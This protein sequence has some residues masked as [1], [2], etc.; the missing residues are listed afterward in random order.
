M[1]AEWLTFTGGSVR[2]SHAWRQTT[3]YRETLCVQQCGFVT[4]TP[5]WLTCTAAERSH[6][7]STCPVAFPAGWW[8]PA[9]N[10][11]VRSPD[12]HSINGRVIRKQACVSL[13][14]EKNRRAQVFLV[15]FYCLWVSGTCLFQWLSYLMYESLLF[16]S[17]DRYTF[18]Q[19]VWLW[20]HPLVVQLLQQRSSHFPQRRATQPSLW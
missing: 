12:R 11:P 10:W 16:S 8:S 2:G 20:P 17:A 19:L 9:S 18:A 15:G 1:L 6:L 7:V 5:P 3:G 13:Q 4:R 14:W